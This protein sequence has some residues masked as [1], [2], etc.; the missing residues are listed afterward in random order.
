[1]TR[2]ELRTLFGRRMM[3]DVIMLVA[4]PRSLNRSQTSCNNTFGFIE[5]GNGH[6]LSRARFLLFIKQRSD[7]GGAR[8]RERMKKRK[9]IKDKIQRSLRKVV[10]SCF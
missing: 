6:L 3:R 2:V 7:V 4:M 8:D 5:F 1:M 9:R 10:I